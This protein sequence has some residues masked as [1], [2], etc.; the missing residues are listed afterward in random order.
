MNAATALGVTLP[1]QLLFRA[2][3]IIE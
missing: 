3:R 1:K 2:D